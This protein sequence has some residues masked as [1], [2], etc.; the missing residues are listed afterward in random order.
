MFSQHTTNIPSVICRQFPNLHQL[1]GVDSKINKL[2]EAAFTH[3]QSLHVLNLLSNEISSIPDNSFRNLPNLD[4]LV[5]GNNKITAI[6]RNIFNGLSNL[7]SLLLDRNFITDLPHGVFNDLKS[8]TVINI[9]NNSIHTIDSR[10]FGDSMQT[11]EVLNGPSNQINQIDHVW[12]DNSPN[13]RGL[14]LM[15]NICTNQNFNNIQIWR[16]EISSDLSDCFNNFGISE[17][18]QGTF[19]SCNYVISTFPQ[20]YM[21]QMSINNPAGFNA[22]RNISGSHLAGHG[23]ANVEAVSIIDQNTQNIPTVICRQFQNLVVLNMILTQTSVLT[24]AAFGF[25]R[26]LE[27]L[28]MNLNQFGFISPRIFPSTLRFL[29][30]DSSAIND[31]H[32]NAFDGLSLIRLS[33]NFNR[34]QVIRPEWFHGIAT[35]IQEVLLNSNSI[36]SIPDGT[37]NG[38]HGLLTIGISGNQLNRLSSASFNDTLRNIMRILAN[39]NQINATDANLF[40]SAVNLQE[41]RLFG[42]ICANENFE[43]IQFNR[44]FVRQQLQNCFNNF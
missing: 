20:R 11:L 23:N 21:C 9:W 32:E 38:L 34:L 12:F 28:S 26:R 7:D 37:F 14:F 41:L 43:N 29:N 8:I 40:D 5:L 19:I 35:T 31:V 17:T 30:L 3:C 6:N 25:C 10:S 13:L 2:T 33:M 1:I 39:N 4:T 27:E 24:P 15:S 36:T 42:N 22:F 18:P 44:E 16:D